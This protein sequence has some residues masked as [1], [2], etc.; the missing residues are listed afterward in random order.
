MVGN[1]YSG[2]DRVPSSHKKTA[3]RRLLALGATRSP[4]WRE[5]A[6]LV[7]PGVGPGAAHHFLQH[8]IGR[9]HQPFHDLRGQERQP[10]DPATI[11]SDA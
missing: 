2:G 8:G 3:R 9:A 10:H 1:S 11:T 5:H 4:G 7:A 6:H